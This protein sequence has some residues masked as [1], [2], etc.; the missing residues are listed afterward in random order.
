MAK[1]KR[2]SK[3]RQRELKAPAPPELVEKL[4]DLDRGYRDYWGYWNLG[5]GRKAIDD[6]FGRARPPGSKISSPP[7][8]SL[9]PSPPPTATLPVFT[10]GQKREFVRTIRRNKNN[11]HRQVVSR[12]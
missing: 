1:A 9:T 8:Q 4:R 2:K 10:A 3:P 6:I 11:R 12:E 7:P 5:A